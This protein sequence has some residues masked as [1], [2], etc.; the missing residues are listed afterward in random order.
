MI[1]K[2]SLENLKD[3]HSESKD[4]E[5]DLEIEA[6]KNK[7]SQD[8][9]HEMK[10][11]KASLDLESVP[12]AALKAE[13]KSEELGLES[14]TKEASLDL[15]SESQV[16]PQIEPDTKVLELKNESRIIAQDL[17]KDIVD[18]ETGEFI[19]A[20]LPNAM[21]KKESD[22]G[23][24]NNEK[25]NIDSPNDVQNNENETPII[26]SNEI[27][28]SPKSTRSESQETP[29]KSEVTPTVSIEI[30]HVDDISED[31]SPILQDSNGM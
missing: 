13:K 16:E 3:F 14:T 2:P 21:K 28:P 31:S 20:I 23:K 30:E 5:A 25:K 24:E 27:I 7:T 4:F 29:I 8:L 19:E 11:I 22:G 26:E 9:E 15:E 12:H 6:E 1:R 18:Q 10:N 17:S